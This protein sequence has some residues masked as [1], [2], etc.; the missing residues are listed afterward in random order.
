MT[1]PSPSRQIARELANISTD[2]AMN[3]EWADAGLLIWLISLDTASC[4]RL[5]P[6]RFSSATPCTRARGARRRGLSDDHRLLRRHVDGK[7]AGA[8][9]VQG[10][11]GE[12]ALARVVAEGMTV[13]RNVERR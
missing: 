2:R 7:G 12:D 10:H 13:A 1:E 3:P 5:R 9:A 11:L 6:S 8:T 4:V